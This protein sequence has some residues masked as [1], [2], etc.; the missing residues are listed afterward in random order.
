[1]MYKIVK[2]KFMAFKLMAVICLCFLLVI[3]GKTATAGALKGLYLCGQVLIPSLFPFMILATFTV[4]S[5]LSDLIGKYFGR[6]TKLIFGVSGQCTATIILSFFGGFPVGAKGISAL[7]EKGKIN[8]KEAEKLAYSLVC[9]G[10]GFLLVFVGT[11]LLNCIEAGI[12]I[13]ASQIISVI[14]LGFANKFIL[15]SEELISEKENKVTFPTEDALISSVRDATYSMVE[16]CG[17]VVVFSAFI[18]ILEKIFI[19]HFDIFTYLTAVFEVTTASKVLS[20]NKNIV[21][22]AFAV[23][24]GG[25]SVHFQIFQALKNVPVKKN[26]FILFR[27]IQGIITAAFTYLFIKLFNISIPVYSSVTDIDFS[28]STSVMGSILL[29][30]TGLCFLNSFKNYKN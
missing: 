27:F 28:L 14:I 30:L 11:T 9:A 18:S 20:E 6:L 25:L 26:I 29:L 17:I 1:M 15:K 22:L 10:P 5:G 8:E 19:N 24:F 23:G 16:M 7:Y 12:C 13:F 4:K 2:E 21:M 3:W